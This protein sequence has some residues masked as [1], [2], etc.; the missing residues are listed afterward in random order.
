MLPVVAVLEMQECE[1]SAGY[2]KA[3]IEAIMA[4]KFRGSSLESLAETDAFK[5]K[6]LWTLPKKC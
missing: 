4:L 6:R 1:C 3:D 2:P 5:G